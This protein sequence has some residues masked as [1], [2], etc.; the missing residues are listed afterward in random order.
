VGKKVKGKENLIKE[1]KGKKNSYQM[2]NSN[3]ESH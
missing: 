3:P 2:I 1:R